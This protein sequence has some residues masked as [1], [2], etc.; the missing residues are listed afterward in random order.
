M[1]KTMTVT[2]FLLHLFLLSAQTPDTR[3][4]SQ[5]NTA[6]SGRQV[7]RLTAFLNAHE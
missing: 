5:P 2:M 4:E 6:H 7:R 3:A 1:V